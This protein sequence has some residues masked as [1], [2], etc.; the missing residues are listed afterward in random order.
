M[1]SRFLNI[2]RVIAKPGAFNKE[3]IQGGVFIVK[4]VL[5]FPDIMLLYGGFLGD[6]T[7]KMF[8]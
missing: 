8:L 2:N 5:V 3:R 6:K 7:G 4:S 1:V